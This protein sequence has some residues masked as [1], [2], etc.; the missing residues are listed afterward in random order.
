M[1]LSQERQ[2]LIESVSAGV[3]SCHRA[4]DALDDAVAARFGVN[5]TDLRHLE[6][7]YAGPLS[8][9][10]LSERSGL[11]PAAMTSLIDRLERKGYVRRVRDAADRRRV[12]VELT[13]LAR[14]AACELYGPVAEE[15]RDLLA[16][17]SDDQLA[18]LRDYLHAQGR[19]SERHHTK[20]TSTR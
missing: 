9:G 11:S 4:A 14:H 19:L 3:R 7:L 10:Q 12:F 1:G 18:L 8:A 20:L 5:R 6:L 15:A 16:G 17:Y 2:A 13:D